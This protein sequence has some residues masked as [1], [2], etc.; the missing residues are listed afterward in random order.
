[1]KKLP[2][3]QIGDTV[4]IIAPSSRCEIAIVN[5]LKTLLTRWQLNCIVPDDL[6][7]NDLLCANTD[8]MRFEHLKNAL[9]RENTKAIITV[10][11]G[12][13]S[14]RLIPLLKNLTP[15]A[16]AK[17]FIGMSDTTALQLYLQQQ[18]QWP[19]IHG[20]LA[21]DKF[22]P[23]SIDAVKTILFHDVEE[24][25]FVEIVPL[26]N[27]ATKEQ[28]IK[29]SVTGG[30]LSLVQVGI[31]TDWEIQAHNQI[32]FLEETSERGYRVDRM[33]EQLSQTRLLDNASAILFGDFTHC[34]E[35]NGSSLIPAVLGRFAERCPFPVA[36]IQGIGHDYINFPLPLGT[37]A[38]LH[39]GKSLKLICSR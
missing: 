35:P 39:C 1:M 10:R 38:T 18:W 31:G 19:T 28:V 6:F 3:L 20:S 2:S 21:E 25:E 9:M 23:E 22:S 14:M 27:A 8:E 26:N 33:L 17:I 15:P 34:N 13:G 16:S 29:G 32:I 37:K 4:E 5:S 24:V 30:N 12:Y 11:G 7:G 36:R